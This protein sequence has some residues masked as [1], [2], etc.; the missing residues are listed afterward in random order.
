MHNNIEGQAAFSNGYMSLLRPAK[1]NPLHE[2]TNFFMRNIFL[3]FSLFIF[4][5]SAISQ[6]CDY[7]ELTDGCECESS[8]VVCNSEIDGFMG[9]LPTDDCGNQPPTFCD[10]SGSIE[11]PLWF[12]FVALSNTVEFVITPDNCTAGMGGFIGMQAAV[13]AN[14]GDN[15]TFICEGTGTE[16]PITIMASNFVVGQTYYLI[17]DGYGGSVCDFIIDAVQGISSSQLDLST[18]GPNVITGETGSVCVEEGKIFSFSIPDCEVSG[19]STFSDLWEDGWTCYDW[20]ITPNTYTII[21][22]EN[23]PFLEVQFDEKAT[24]TI[25]VD[26]F[27]HPQIEGCAMGSCEDPAAIELSVCIIDTVINTTVLCPGDLEEICGNLIG[28]PGVY[29]CLD[30]INC[31]MHIDTVKMSTPEVEELGN[32]FLCPDE[33]FELEG[34]QYCDRTDYNIQSIVDCSKAFTFSIQDLSINIIPEPYPVVNCNEED[35]L[36]AHTVNTNYDGTI[37][38]KYLDN[39]DVE[40]SNTNFVLINQPGEYRFIVFV[41]GFESSCADTVEF[42]IEIDDTPVEFELEAEVLTCADQEALV[43]AISNENIVSYSWSG[44]NIQGPI[45]G[46]SITAVDSGTYILVVEGENGCTT[47]K[48]IFV[49]ANYPPIDVEVN[50]EELDC[51]IAQTTLSYIASL[52]IDSVLWAGPNEFKGSTEEVI[53]VDTGVYVLNLFASNG[54]DYSHIFKVLGNYVDPEFDALVPDEW[55]CKSEMLDIEIDFDPSLN[56]SVNW[57]AND[58]IILGANNGMSLTV[59]STGEYVVEVTDDLT[60]CS[61]LDTIFVVANDEVPTSIDIES[62]SPLCFNI[63]DGIIDITNIEGGTGPFD[64]FLNGDLQSSMFI[65]NLAPASYEV[66]AVDINGC[67]VKRAIEIEAPTELVAD[68][69]GPEEANYGDNVLIE[70]VVDKEM[71]DIDVINW[72]DDAGMYLGSGDDINFTMEANTSITMEVVDNNGCIV[73]QVI[74]IR[75]DEDYDYY[76]PNMF[77]PNQD[78][79][80]DY[81]AIFTQDLPGQIDLLSIYDRWGNKMFEVRNIENGNDDPSWGWDGL[82]NGQVVHSGVYVYYAEVE[83]LGIKKQLKGSVTLVR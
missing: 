34:V 16:N 32:I 49:D 28:A 8:I 65:E 45:N 1:P 39:N 6:T 3:L 66:L 31:I 77:T 47:E 30:E 81:F 82:F 21:G 19:S 50:Y 53:A 22:D 7:P 69:E 10:G 72:Y 57:F 54:C 17:I 44:P 29:E 35:E 83:T 33:C 23:T 41:E 15:D 79:F 13:Y 61:S 38:F 18:E 4:G 36:V 26:R 24:Y 25:S 71:F 80:N 63:N 14:C 46:P 64:I 20:T 59:G 68:I 51:K 56:Y 48:E 40:L 58:G 11:N 5:N 73:T 12:S 75:L 37:S 27:L 67:E 70:S 2:R 55:A 60:G 76:V 78:G 9:T 74:S 52:E 62:T 43:E 42:T